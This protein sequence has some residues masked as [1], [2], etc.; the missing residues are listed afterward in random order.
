MHEM[1]KCVLLNSC[2]LSTYAICCESCKCCINLSGEYAATYVHKQSISRP[3]VT[4]VYY[5]EHFYW[6]EYDDNS[7][8]G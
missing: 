5:S 3:Y 1:V 8:A 7:N 4:R 6:R 2:Q